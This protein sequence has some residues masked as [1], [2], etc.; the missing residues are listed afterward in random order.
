MRSNA[1][2]QTRLAVLDH[3][4]D[5]AR[6]HLERRPAAVPGA[7][8]CVAEAGVEEAGVVGAQLARRR[9]VGEHL[10]RIA[11]RDAH[12]LGREQ[13]VEDLGLE[14]DPPAALGVH[15]LPEVLASAARPRP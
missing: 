7:V 11:G 9:V 1:S 5:V 13:Q 3:E 6:A 4:R 15:G 14:H 10:R 2:L 12:A 8:A